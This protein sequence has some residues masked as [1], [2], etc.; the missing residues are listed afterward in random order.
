MKKPVGNRGGERSFL[1]PRKNSCSAEK[2]QGEKSVILCK[3]ISTAS[4]VINEPGKKA[5]K[6]VSEIWANSVYKKEGIERLA[7]LS[8]ASVVLGHCIWKGN[9]QGVWKKSKISHE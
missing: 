1:V 6:N 4:G 2:K 3:G 7:G 5:S 8:G 9:G